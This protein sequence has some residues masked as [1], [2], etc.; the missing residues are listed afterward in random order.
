M[1]TIVVIS[2]LSL[3]LVMLYTSYSA[4][5]TNIENRGSYDN[6]EYIYKTVVIRNFLE[7]LSNVSLSSEDGITYCQNTINGNTRKCYLPDACDAND[8][9]CELFEFLKVEGVYVTDW[10]ITNLR[11][12]YPNTLD[13]TT[14]RYIKSLDPP[15]MPAGTKRIIVM[16]KDENSQ[17]DYP[18]YQYA[19]LKIKIGG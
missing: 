14:K 12:N 7:N 6:T 3:I 11:N 15:K 18:Q 17:K 16:Y 13:A 8:E 19:T 9:R 4:T 1:E 10:D 5:L 2:V